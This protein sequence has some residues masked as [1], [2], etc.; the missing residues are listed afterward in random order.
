[1]EP[2][3]RVY[4]TRPTTLLT[5]ILPI[6]L[7]SYGSGTV[8]INEVEL[9]PAG[10]DRSQDVLEWVELYN[11][12]NEYV[13]ISD[14]ALVT[15]HGYKE[16]VRI[17][18]GSL[19]EAKGFYAIPDHPPKEQWLDNKDETVVLKDDSGVEIDRTPTLADNRG[20][21]CA[22]SR[23]PDG[24]PD[25][26]FM[27][28]S[29]GARA[30]GDFCYSGGEDGALNCCFEEYDDGSLWNVS[31]LNVGCQ[32]D[33]CLIETPFI[34][35]GECE[36]SNEYE[37][38][39][40]WEL[41]ESTNVSDLKFEMGQ[42][43][44]GAGFVNLDNHVSGS[45]I[46]LNTKEHG[47]GTYQKDEQIQVLRKNR[48]AEVESG[49][50]A[51]Y[52][53]TTLGLPHNRS[54]TYSSKWS[55]E[56]CAKTQIEP[57]LVGSNGSNGQNVYH[58]PWCWHVK[59]I[60]PENLI[61]FS[62]LEDAEKGGRRPCKDCITESSMHE[63]YRYITSIARESYIKQDRN[64]S[65]L[66]FDSD[67]EGMGHIGVLRKSNLDDRPQGTPTFESREDYTG[68]FRIL[69][70]IEDRKS[71]VTYEKSAEG[72]GFVAVNKEIGATQK[73]YEYGTGTYDSEEEINTAS[74][75]MAKDISVIHAPTSQSL[76][77]DVSLDQ[78]LKW[79]EGMWSKT[80]RGVS[81]AKSTQASRA[82][83]KRPKSEA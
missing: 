62:S 81:S 37:C 77:D 64:V 42:E 1:V 12:G 65:T 79:K 76:T 5:L 8:I 69:E 74:N 25:W 48:S 23:Y 20:D 56:A 17:P 9:N 27:I 67:F 70:M 49:I 22:W 57:P 72:Q 80:Q 59:T 52:K 71:G 15:T 16:I 18:S 36:T 51:N 30:S 32:T 78:D 60:E 7:I 34:E 53:I 73:T 26:E 13:D 75:Y 61:W 39:I 6:F 44:N 4:Q 58:Y 54:V 28:S 40:E 45:G 11:T 19:I 3:W 68:S 46:E 2:V 14:W 21:S 83:T 10:D 50:S 55:E 31:C 38:W 35:S 63:S 66:K 41:N 43:V 33:S 47:S 82:S 24:S 29:K